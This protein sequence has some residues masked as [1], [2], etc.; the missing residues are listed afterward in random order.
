MGWWPA[1]EQMPRGLRNQ[2]TFHLAD[3][4]RNRGAQFR[5]DALVESRGGGESGAGYGRRTGPRGAGIAGR[6]SFPAFWHWA[7]SFHAVSLSRTQNLTEPRAQQRLGAEE[8]QHGREDRAHYK[9]ITRSSAGGDFTCV[10]RRRPLPPAVRPVDSVAHDRH[11]TTVG[12]QHFD[13]RDLILRS[14]PVPGS[15]MPTA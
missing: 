12:E 11:S 10:S 2:R 1:H 7:A 3:G 14:R 13:N 15:S 5:E 6:R 8:K 9:I 4:R